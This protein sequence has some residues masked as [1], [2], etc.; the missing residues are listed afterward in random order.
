MKPVKEATSEKDVQREM[1]KIKRNEEGYKWDNSSD[2]NEEHHYI[3]VGFKQIE[4]KDI[5]MRVKVTAFLEGNKYKI[6]QSYEIKGDIWSNE[7]WEYINTNFTSEINEADVFYTLTGTMEN[8]NGLEI[9]Q[10]GNDLLSKFSG[11]FVEGL[12]EE[13][14][15]SLSAYSN[16]LDSQTLLVNNKKI[17]LQLGLRKNQEDNV[18]DVT[19]GTPII[20]S[21]Y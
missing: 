11:T 14:F 18:I 9:R 3:A 20:T 16:L 6:Y 10:E 8:K 13:D 4:S 15:V 7:V 5:E 1:E 12:I 2:E 21:G 17:N 19:I